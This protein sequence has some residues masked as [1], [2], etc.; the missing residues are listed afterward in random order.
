MVRFR[1]AAYRPVYAKCKRFRALKLSFENSRPLGKGTNKRHV[2][3]MDLWRLVFHRFAQPSNCF[4]ASPHIRRVVAVERS[5]AAVANNN[6]ITNHDAI[7]ND[8]AIADN[9]AVAE[10][11]TVTE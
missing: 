9:D 10:H 11:Q 8:D 7:T 1:K 2:G 5:R 3:E 6:A 4:T